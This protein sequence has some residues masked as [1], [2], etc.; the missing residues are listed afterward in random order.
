MYRWGT[1]LVTSAFIINLLQN[2]L[3]IPKIGNF[4]K[5]VEIFIVTFH[6]TF[7]FVTHEKPVH[8]VYGSFNDGYSL[9]NYF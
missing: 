6:R 4:L 1:Q 2:D 7:F 9:V 5:F 8:S 3:H